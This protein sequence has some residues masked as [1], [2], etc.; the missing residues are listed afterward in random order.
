MNLKR[1]GNWAM[2]TGCSTG[3]GRAFADVL[4][5]SGLNCVLVGLEGERLEQFSRE[6]VRQYGVE[7]RFREVDLAAEGFLKEVRLITGGI[8]IDILV[9]NAGIGC[10]G[11]FWSVDATKAGTLV[12]LNCLAPVLLTREFLPGM[13]ERGRGA[14]VMVASV[15][16][17]ISAPGEAAYNAS[18]AFDLHF[19]ESLWG[20]LRG[21]LVDVITVCPAGIRSDFY[22][23]EGFSAPDRK[24]MRDMSDAPEKIARATFKYL[25]RK[26][27]YAPP[28]SGLI[29]F[30]A[31]LLPRRVTTLAVRSLMRKFI[32]FYR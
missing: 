8:D 5:S 21:S 32:R 14:I 27:V 15:M 4:A 11:N 30:C 24:R 12:R 28:V 23:R 16:G 1:Y 6:L 3:L 18:K 2:V 20:E 19:G 31:R 13:V 25:G 22:E 29:G 26:P 9:N 17:F 10:G 7:C